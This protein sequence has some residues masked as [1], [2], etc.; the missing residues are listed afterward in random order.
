MR[1]CRNPPFLRTFITPPL[2]PTPSMLNDSVM[3]PAHVVHEVPDIYLARTRDL[4]PLR[5]FTLVLIL[6]FF[7]WIYDM[8]TTAVGHMCQ[9][10]D[11]AQT[12][13]DYSPG[14]I[15]SPSLLYLV[16]K[17]QPTFQPHGTIYAS[18]ITLLSHVFLHMA[19]MAICNFHILQ[20]HP[21]G[22]RQSMRMLRILSR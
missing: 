3:V 20:T 2:S 11:R 4:P 8:N 22:F 7:Q 18:N 16:L 12:F 6:I 14:I 10:N 15:V 21:T 1:I 19:Q 13:R 17:L 9:R 5:S